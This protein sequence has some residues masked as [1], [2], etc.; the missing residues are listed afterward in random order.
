ML[1]GSYSRIRPVAITRGRRRR[2]PPASTSAVPARPS[3]PRRA[4]NGRPSKAAPSPHPQASLAGRTTRRV[5]VPQPAPGQCRRDQLAGVHGASEGDSARLIR[6]ASR[7][8]TRRID[9]GHR[10]RS[11]TWPL[12]TR[13]SV[14]AASRARRRAT[15]WATA[16]RRSSAGDRRN[17]LSPAWD[18]P[19]DFPTELK[20][21]GNRALSTSSTSSSSLVRAQLPPSKGRPADAVVGSGA[22]GFWKRRRGPVARK[23]QGSQAGRSARDGRAP[24][25]ASSALI[26]EWMQW[27]ARFNPV[28]RVERTRA[29][30]PGPSFN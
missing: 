3:A 17:P 13:R 19:T 8:H 30:L 4:P 7:L 25:Q 11:A 22:P 5:A 14:L 23:W 27:A 1:G 21:A 29:P 26:P 15:S 2:S 9:R 18:F 12:A 6:R 28:H 20:R 10:R 24:A 16:P